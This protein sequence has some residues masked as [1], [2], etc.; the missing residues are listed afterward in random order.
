MSAPS[1]P[2]DPATDPAYTPYGEGVDLVRDLLARSPS[3]VVV[4]T[5][6]GLIRYVNQQLEDLFGYTR[7]ELDGRP[8]EVIA[9]PRLRDDLR[10]RVAAYLEAP[11]PV[12]VTER[13]DLTAMRKDGT[14]LPIRTTTTPVR[15]R[16][17]LWIVVTIFDVSA[18]RAAAARIE[19][20]KRSYL[21]LARMNEAIV[22][23]RDV[24]TLYRETCR[25]AVD[26]GGFLAAWVGESDG[27]GHIR[28]I[29]TAGALDGYVH[30]L[31]LSTDPADPRSQGPTGTA[32]REERP[33][34]SLDFEADPTT[35]PWQDAASGL[36][37]ASS[38][39]LPLRRGGRTVAVLSLYAERMG[40]F[41]E[42]AGALLDGLAYN[43]SF[44]LD[45]LDAASR[46]ERVSAHRHQLLQ[47]L[48]NAQE[49]ERRRIAAD[50]HD[51]SVQ[52]LAAVDLRLAM[53]EGSVQAE[54]PQLVDRVVQVR[55][56]LASTTASL[57]ELMFDLEP[58][59]TAGSVGTAVRDVAEHALLGAP[60]RCEV[61][62]E[63]VELP[64]VQLA[65]A[66][67]ITKEALINVR[68]HARASRVEVGVRRRSNGVEFTI[69]DD[70]IGY[71]GSLP[72]ARPGHRGLRTMTERAEVS[73]GWLQVAR[74]EP[75]GVEVTFW[76]PDDV[77]D[78]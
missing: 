46:L 1:T 32:F 62:A 40:V 72:D 2:D 50:I 44:A 26:E 61:H 54:A 29:A 53:L 77:G 17:G 34:F 16:H 71:D 3:P 33:V 25:V 14:E 47:R 19:T 13:P 49:S 20:L 78:A 35:V 63:E 10:A 21:T 43:V 48:V 38:V 56:V 73:D 41:D 52:A 4:L 15:N 67:R 51:D 24:T 65:Q 8:Y 70:G 55:Q 6:D 42:E 11:D 9:P 37:I 39:C 74:A 30:A 22:R 58:A 28:P 31:E 23:A 57:R 59:D 76:L 64:E 7:A 69:T 36:G 60:I 75:S 27:R 66:L 45:S 5:S 12:S 18:E 68:K